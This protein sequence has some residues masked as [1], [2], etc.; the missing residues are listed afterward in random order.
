MLPCRLTSPWMPWS[1]LPYG[2]S[3]WRSSFASC[4]GPR[5]S[6]HQRLLLD[7]QRGKQIFLWRPWRTLWRVVAS[8]WSP[9]KSEHQRILLDIQ[10]VQQTFLWRPWRTLW[11]A[12][13]KVFIRFLLGSSQV[14]TAETLIIHTERKANISLEALK[15]IM[16]GLSFLLDSSQVWTSET[17]IIHTERK[18]NSSL[19]AL[20]NIMEVL[21]VGV[22]TFVCFAW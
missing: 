3:C 12:L 19:E 11:R 4:W 15:N 22:C 8:C 20:K 5:K 2:G 6:E 13:L 7:I 21:A 9:R 16:E 1:S 18:A 14:W 10:R 17:L